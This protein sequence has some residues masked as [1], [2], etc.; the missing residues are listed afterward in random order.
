[1]VTL[2][3]RALGMSGATDSERKQWPSRIRALHELVS[4][5]IPCGSEAARTEL[6][7][8]SLSGV[9][10]AYMNWVDRL[11]PPRQRE[12]LFAD[13]FWSSNN[14]AE[15]ADDIRRLARLIGEGGDLLP[16]LSRYAR[17]HGYEAA[18]QR[19]GIQ[20]QNK[21]GGHKDFALNAYG[22][23]HLH[24]NACD[25]HGRHPGG[26]RELLY[27]E[28]TRH[29]AVF[30]MLGDHRSFDDGTLHRAV[31]EYRAK[32]GWDIKGIVGLRRPMSDR[33]STHL[34]R[35]GVSGFGQVGDTVVLTG[36]ISS[37]GTSVE[38]TR[39]ADRIC[40]FLEEYEPKLDDSV[41][42]KGWE[43]D[44]GIPASALLTWHFRYG[45]FGVLDESARA[46]Y[47]LLKWRR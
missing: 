15:H 25:N 31:T 11:I 42:R 35:H 21:T 44:Y 17:T 22:V 45:D 36:M 5:A 26:S 43:Q 37:A 12:V 8:E 30:L 6:R 13:G 38:H 32:C 2:A 16:H 41:F 33:E 4:E 14:V 19:R 46:F 39:W 7:A 18:R 40:I 1:M 24:L 47:V 29:A 10:S 9:L 3:S 23:H 27:A 34:L 20:W 28:V